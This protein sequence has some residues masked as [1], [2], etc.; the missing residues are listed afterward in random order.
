M[1]YIYIKSLSKK[2]LTF[3][4]YPDN[5]EHSITIYFY[6]C[7]FKCQGCSNPELQKFKCGE[8]INPHSLYHELQKLMK[9]LNTNK[10]TLLGGDPF[11]LENRSGLFEFLNIN[12]IFEVCIYT[13]YEWQDIKKYCEIFKPLFVKTGQYNDE[14]KQKSYKTTEEMQFASSNQELYQLINGEYQLISQNGLYKF[15]Q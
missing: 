9:E 5:L 11:S 15:N 3:L 6:G 10:I 12:K 8:D 4:D 7:D 2:S 13:G 1:S 14:L